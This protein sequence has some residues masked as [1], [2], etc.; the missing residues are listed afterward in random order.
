MNEKCVVRAAI[1]VLAFVTMMPSVGLSQSGVTEQTPIEAWFYY[2]E[3]SMPQRTMDFMYL[4]ANR[5][6]DLDSADWNDNPQYVLDPAGISRL[7]T[8]DIVSVGAEIGR[9]RVRGVI[10]GY[11]PNNDPAV[12]VAG[13][14][15]YVNL[16]QDI[17]DWGDPANPYD[18]VFVRTLIA[19]RIT[20]A[21]PD[22]GADDPP[23]D[24]ITNAP[25]AGKHVYDVAEGMLCRDGGPGDVVIV[26]PDEDLTVV[27]STQAYDTRVAGVISEDPKL[28][29]GPEAGKQPVALAGVVRC[30]VSAENGAIVP[31]DMLVSAASAGH[32]MRAERRNV[33][34]GMLVGKALQPLP[35]GT[36]QIYILVNKQ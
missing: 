23:R 17:F 1:T 12:S 5:M 9:L 21:V 27:R 20:M 10:L 7:P 22:G 36:G 28:H 25:Y 18:S 32:A 11:D 15:Y 19:G 29:L 3:T 2:P 30:K 31:G 33:R 8:M 4:R 13:E 24:E 16:N 6:V 34:P 14:T 26:S 35:A